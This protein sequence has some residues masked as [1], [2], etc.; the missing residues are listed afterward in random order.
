MMP[1]ISGYI[2]TRISPEG[3]RKLAAWNLDMSILLTGPAMA[4]IVLFPAVGMAILM[5][6][7]FY[8]ITITALDVL[9]TSDVRVQQEDGRG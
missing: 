9:S 5:F 7:S 2:V 4:A 1:P 6:I 3:R 8:A